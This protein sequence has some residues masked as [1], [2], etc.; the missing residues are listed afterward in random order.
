MSVKCRKH[1]ACILRMTYHFENSDFLFLKPN[2]DMFL[3]LGNTG[4]VGQVE[5][6]DIYSSVC[7]PPPAFSW[8][9]CPAPLPH[10][11]ATVDSHD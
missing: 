9:L 4:F 7:S 6:T 3:E 2:S 8:E 5:Q 11:M 10:H 1:I